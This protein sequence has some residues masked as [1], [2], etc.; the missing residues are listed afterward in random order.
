MRRLVLAVVCAGA[1]TAPVARAQVLALPGACALPALGAAPIVE[2]PGGV[3]GR[4][5]WSRVLPEAVAL[6][7]RDRTI[8]V[9]PAA[10]PGAVAAVLGPDAVPIV[11]GPGTAALALRAPLVAGGRPSARLATLA[12]AVGPDVRLVPSGKPV[13]VHALAAPSVSLLLHGPGAAALAPAVLSGAGGLAPRAEARGT[14]VRAVLGAAGT[15]RAARVLA[16]VEAAPAIAMLELRLVHPVE[17]EA[18]WDAVT[19]DAPLRHYGA[20][21]AELAVW[22]GGAGPIAE[23]LGVVAKLPALEVARRVALVPGLVSGVALE[24]GPCAQSIDPGPS[25]G[26]RVLFGAHSVDRSGVALRMFGPSGAHPL[27]PLLAV[28]LVPG[29]G[30]AVRPP[31]PPGAVLWG[32]VRI[33][34]AGGVS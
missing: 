24:L 27:V 10:L 19:R 2:L 34:V 1:F 15:R 22:T 16:L 31:G 20:S 8:D 23:T 14:A 17:S 30:V 26:A 29:A 18:F 6:P 21:G 28:R 13:V 12:R 4:W 25:R 5:S 11:S 9:A 33:L 3:L 32:E 7:G